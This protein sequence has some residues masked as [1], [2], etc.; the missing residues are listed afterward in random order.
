MEAGPGPVRALLTADGCVLAE[1]PQGREGGSWSGTSSDKAPSHHEGS[2]PLTSA[3]PNDLP[4]A[5]FPRPP[6]WGLGPPHWNI[7]QTQQV[8]HNTGIYLVTIQTP[9]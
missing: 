4:K 5:P 9:N 7:G 8:V 2:A 6:P 1:S 3:N